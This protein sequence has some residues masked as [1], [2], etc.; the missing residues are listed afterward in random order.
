MLTEVSGL[1]HFKERNLTEYGTRI[2]DF[3]S[4]KVLHK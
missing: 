2:K 4:F 1:G 3:L